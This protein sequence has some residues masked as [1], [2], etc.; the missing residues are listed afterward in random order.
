MSTEPFPSLHLLTVQATVP[1]N[2]NFAELRAPYWRLYWNPDV[3]ALVRSGGRVY[4]LG[5]GN[6]LLIPPETSFGTEQACAARHFY[7]HFLTQPAW[8][9]PAVLVL[10]TDSARRR[11]LRELFRRPDRLWDVAALV[12]GC[13]AK[14]DSAGWS[15]AGVRR[16]NVRRAMEHLE[17]VLPLGTT[18]PDL[19]ARAGMDVNGFIRAFRDET[20]RTPAAYVRE[21]RLAASCIFLHHSTHTI[22]RIAELCGFCDRHHFT[23]AFVASRGI[24]PAAFRKQGAV[25]G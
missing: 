19:A 25:R 21:R 8:R 18:V 12:S 14:L 1:P 23:R 10:E 22:E 16:E 20:G 3:G 11:V 4:P 6:I 24:S 7:V 5:P 17:T 15:R 2:W 13:L 9:T